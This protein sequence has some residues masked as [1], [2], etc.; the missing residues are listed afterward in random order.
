MSGKAL[1]FRR[2]LRKICGSAALF[3]QTSCGL[4]GKLRLPE[5]LTPM[6][7]A[8]E[9]QCTGETQCT[10]LAFVDLRNAADKIFDAGIKTGLVGSTK[11]PLLLKEG[12]QPLR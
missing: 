5:C 9:V 7:R 12:W 8:V 3:K 2:I 1:P 4:N 6:D 11:A 10:D